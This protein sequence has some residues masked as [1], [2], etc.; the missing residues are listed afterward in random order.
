[1]RSGYGTSDDMASIGR[2]IVEAITE[3]RTTISA[4]LGVI[5]G[6]GALT[7]T[8]TTSQVIA[9]PRVQAGSCIALIPTDAASA[10]QQAGAGMMFVN[11]AAIVPGVS[12]TIAPANGV[13]PASGLVFRYT[14]HNPIG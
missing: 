10:A 1:M 4:A 9:E 13:A 7:T 2:A 8:A 14:I 6:V 5:A 11:V 3:L 12:F